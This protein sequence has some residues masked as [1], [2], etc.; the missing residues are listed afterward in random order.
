MAEGE[1]YTEKTVHEGGDTHPAGEEEHLEAVPP[2][3]LTVSGL[4]VMM[5]VSAAVGLGGFIGFC[6]K[7]VLYKSRQ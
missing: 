7:E 5:R 6:F 3:M 4:H 1:R 2:S